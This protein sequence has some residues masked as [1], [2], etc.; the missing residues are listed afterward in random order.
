[1]QCTQ[2]PRDVGVGLAGSGQHRRS[3]RGVLMGLGCAR[4]SGSVTAAGRQAGRRQGAGKGRSVM[5]LC[6]LEGAGRACKDKRERTGAH[7]QW[8]CCSISA[9]HWEQESSKPW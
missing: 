5:R 6:Q 8:S 7:L 1:M 9:G 4:G 3:L 2:G